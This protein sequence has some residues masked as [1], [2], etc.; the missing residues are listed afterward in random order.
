LEKRLTHS[1]LKATFTGSNPVRVTIRKTPYRSG[2]VFLLFHQKKLVM[3]GKMFM[4][5]KYVKI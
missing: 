3:F 5:E 1:P 2:M 4:K